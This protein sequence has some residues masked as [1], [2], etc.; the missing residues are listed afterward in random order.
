MFEI[1]YPHSLD[2]RQ[3]VLTPIFNNIKSAESFY[4]VGSASM[5][6]TRLLDF[7]MRQDVQ[8]HYLYEKAS[9]IWLIRVDMNRLSIRSEGWAFFELLLSSIVLEA[10]NHENVQDLR[11]ELLDLDSQV[12]Q[13]RDL[14]LALRL[15]ELAV[16]RLCQDFKLR[17]CFLLD[18][19]DE[20]YQT[21]SRDTFSQLRAVRDA[22]KNRVL[23]G[24]F[25]RN[26][27]EQLRSPKENESFYEL[28]SR[29]PIGIG[30]YT[31]RDTFEMIE[32][33][34]TR[35]QFSVTLEQQE[36]IFRTSGGHP[37]LIL[38]LL[39]VLAERP[40][41]F[42]TIDLPNWANSFIQETTIQDEC[43]KIWDGLSS[44]DQ[45]SLLSVHA[46]REIPSPLKK[47]LFVRG[48]II[49]T[50]RGIQFFSELFEQ[51][52]KLNLT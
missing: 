24:I 13:G 5:G 35:K 14:L 11:T 47:S 51:Y 31:R 42:Q 34:S 45:Q 43:R 28:L 36:K 37:G 49:D 27:P 1:G 30:P 3:E 50:D 9:Q 12:I 17:F 40:Q 22:N 39:D 25:L 23:Y 18:E 46:K 33:I 2:F 44:V 10:S 38:A 8:K 21:L 26:P 32:I 7:L 29:S 20:A 41:L 52:V 16:N 48:L 6:K 4:V 19:F 15:F